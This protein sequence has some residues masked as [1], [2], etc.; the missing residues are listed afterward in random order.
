M[1]G[2]EEKGGWK[3]KYNWTVEDV[4]R[5]ESVEDAISYFE[6]HHDNDLNLGILLGLKGYKEMV[7]GV[8]K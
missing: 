2:Q 5:F 1:A 3:M 6:C 4:G 8:G 7:G